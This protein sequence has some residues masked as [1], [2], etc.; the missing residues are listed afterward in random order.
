[1]LENADLDDDG[2]FNYPENYDY[3]DHTITC[4][5]ADANQCRERSQYVYLSSVTTF[6]VTG[7]HKGNPATY[8]DCCRRWNHGNHGQESRNS[9]A[10]L[11]SSSMPLL[12]YGFE[13]SGSPEDSTLQNDSGESG[14]VLAIANMI[15]S[16]DLLVRWQVRLLCCAIDLSR[17]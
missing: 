10:W 1:M 14:V 2:H 13:P 11:Q 16:F 7:W 15:S 9:D 5:P 12:K 4:R 8:P 17:N 6:A 3:Y